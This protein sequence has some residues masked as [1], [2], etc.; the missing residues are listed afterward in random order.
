MSP[1][2]SYDLRSFWWEVSNSHLCSVRDVFF[3]SLWLPSRFH[4]L[5]SAI[6]TFCLLFILLRVLGTSWICSLRSLNIL[7]NHWPLSSN[8]PPALFPPL[9]SNHTWFSPSDDAPQLLDALRF[10]FVSSSLFLF[11]LQFGWFLLACV[12][13]CWFFPQLCW[14]YWWALKALFFFVTFIFISSIPFDSS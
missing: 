5:F 9:Q 2:L 14:V 4:L 11:V 12:Q 10:G 8:I 6:W 3:P 1:R 7:E 13:V